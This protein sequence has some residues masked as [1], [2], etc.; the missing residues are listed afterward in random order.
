MSVPIKPN[1]QIPGTP[2]P[3]A[4]AQSMYPPRNMPYQPPTTYPQQ[5]NTFQN[6]NQP[7][8]KAPL[9]SAKEKK[10]IHTAFF[11]NIPYNIPFETFNQF[12]RQF[13][14]IAN[15]YSL[16]EKKGYAFVTYYDIRNAEKAVEEGDKKLLNGRDIR[17]NYANKSFFPHRDPRATCACILLRCDKSPSNIQLSDVFNAM[18]E[19]GEIQQ[20]TP[21]DQ[22]GTFIVKYYDIRHAQAAY[23]NTKQ[24]LTIRDE[25]L[26]MDFLID[27]EDNESMSQTNPATHAVYPQQPYIPQQPYP[28]AYPQQPP[29]PSYGMPMAPY[30]VPQPP[31]PNYGVPPPAEQQG[32]MQPPQPNYGMPQ[33]QQQYQPPIQGQPPQ[34]PVSQM[35]SYQQ[36]S[37]DK[38]ATQRS[39]QRL[40]MLFGGGNNNN[41][42]S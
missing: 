21:G 5:F 35:P 34:Q 31:P 32:M 36:P 28:Q 27:D 23:H 3:D 17:T 15:M 2:A 40:K 42:N 20:A 22:P 13:G 41:N 26:T 14:E 1:Y 9:V 12:V 25:T 19:F 18:K 16:I 24:K 4:T 10:P 7:R 30:G 8:Q 37:T 33:Q 11:S 29:P 38:A 6:V 39:L